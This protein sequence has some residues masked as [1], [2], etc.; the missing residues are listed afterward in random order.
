MFF[1]NN[2]CSNYLYCKLQNVLWTTKI[3]LS[4]IKYGIKWLDY[5]MIST[6]IGLFFPYVVRL[7]QGIG[8]FPTARQ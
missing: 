6:L 7:R 8:S 4:F 5:Y 1:L 3:L 2:S